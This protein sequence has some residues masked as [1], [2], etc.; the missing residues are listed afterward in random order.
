MSWLTGLAGKAEELLNKVD[1]TANASL[2]ISTISEEGSAIPVPGNKKPPLTVSP[3]TLP[4]LLL[5]LSLSRR[6]LP[7]LVR[8]PARKLW[9]MSCLTSSTVNQLRKLRRSLY[10]RGSPVLALPGPQTAGFSSQPDHILLQMM[11]IIVR[12]TGILAHQPAPATMN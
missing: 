11:L 9:T 1:Q 8:S 3:L 10:T 6:N 12:Q 4:E 5:L 2:N 7:P